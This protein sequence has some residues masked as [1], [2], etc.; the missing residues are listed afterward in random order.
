MSIQLAVT[1][2]SIN[3][4]VYRAQEDHNKGHVCNGV[5]PLHKI[6]RIYQIMY[7]IHSDNI[8]SILLEKRGDAG[9][10]FIPR[11]IFLNLHLLADV[12]GTSTE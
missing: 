6:K 9:G 2:S 4:T 1:A 12:H 11:V 10:K 8:Q 7:S 3:S 5:S